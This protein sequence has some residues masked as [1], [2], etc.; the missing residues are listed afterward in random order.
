MKKASEI[1]MDWLASP[2]HAGTASRAMQS[3]HSAA[4]DAEALLDDAL[5]V[6]ASEH[7]GDP[8]SYIHKR[9]VEIGGG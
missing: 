7:G 1:A 5:A 8:V 4:L 6:I 9:I 3:V 2:R